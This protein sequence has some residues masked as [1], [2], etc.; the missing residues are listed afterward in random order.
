MNSTCVCYDIKLVIIKGKLSLNI[1][2]ISY[3]QQLIINIKL[4][5]RDKENNE[6]DFLKKCILEIRTDN[7]SLAVK[8]LNGTPTPLLPS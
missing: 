6:S 5:M 8:I 4:A 7:P 1:S 2:C 3:I